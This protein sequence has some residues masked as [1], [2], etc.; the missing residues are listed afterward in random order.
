M[1]NRQEAQ[2]KKT[3][4]KGKGMGEIGLKDNYEGEGKGAG[5]VE[6]F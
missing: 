6:G 1:K 2:K 4:P 5:A 3:E